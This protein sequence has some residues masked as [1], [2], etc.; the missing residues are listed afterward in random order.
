MAHTV[1][2]VA[3]L[4]NITVRTLHHYDHMGLLS[5]QTTSQ[6]GYRL[7]TDADLE[8]LQQV[9]FFRELGFSLQEIKEILDHPGFDRR[10]A[11]VSHRNLLLEKQKRLQALIQSVDQTIQAMERGLPMTAQEM[12]EPFDEATMEVYKAEAKERWGHTAAYAESER[13]TSRYTKEDWGLIHAESQ[14]ITLGLAERMDREPGDAEVQALIDRWFLHIND[15][16][17]TCPLEIFRAIGEGYV[18]DPR[19]TRTYDRVK[20]G[21]AVFKR[22]AMRLYCDRGADER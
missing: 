8:R 21:L 1:K 11:L 15:R 5:P 18:D 16:F 4:A 2:A 12:F 6:A 19:F 3:K 7:Y 22:D 13:R 20:K 9:L 14:A 17:Y 10:E